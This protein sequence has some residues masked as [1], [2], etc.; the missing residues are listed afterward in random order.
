MQSLF[1]RVAQATLA[2]ALA[3]SCLVHA[4]E[5]PGREVPAIDLPAKSLTL[6]RPTGDYQLALIK[7]KKPLANGDGFD[8]TLNFKHAGSLT[9]TW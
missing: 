8:L 9:V 1:M 3:A 5:L 7:L 6:L 4:H 2:M